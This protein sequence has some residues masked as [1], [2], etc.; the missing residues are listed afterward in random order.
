MNTIPSQIEEKYNSVQGALKCSLCKITIT[1]G[2]EVGPYGWLYDE[3][4]IKAH[5]CL[6]EGRQS[7]GDIQVREGTEE[8]A[9]KESES[10]MIH[11]VGVDKKRKRTMFDD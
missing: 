3:D 5:T 8:A 6:P 11:L 9:E 7:V 1:Y 2:G 10:P 4:A